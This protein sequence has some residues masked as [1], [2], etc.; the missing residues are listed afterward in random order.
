MLI[1]QPTPLV[2][3]RQSGNLV[4]Y[5][6]MPQMRN[7]K[8]IKNAWQISLY[9]WRMN[10]GQ[11]SLVLEKLFFQLQESPIYQVF[12]V[13]TDAR[14]FGPIT[15]YVP[16]SSMHGSISRKIRQVTSL[17]TPCIHSL[18]SSAMGRRPWSRL[19]ISMSLAA[20]RAGSLPSILWHG[21]Y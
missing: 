15:T 11:I 7:T 19:I 8:I 17:D 12:D 14:L 2:K 13:W 6:D 3:Q 21:D 16:S 18:L 20:T 1:D 5:P 10:A 4:V 9:V